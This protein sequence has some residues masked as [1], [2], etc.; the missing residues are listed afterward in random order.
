[1]CL[2]VNVMETKTDYHRCVHPFGSFASRLS[3]VLPNL[4]P[5]EGHGDERLTQKDELILR[6]CLDLLRLDAA[7]VIRRWVLM[8]KWLLKSMSES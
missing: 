3:P 7:V 2:F 6:S 1:M 5:T 8:G 4:S